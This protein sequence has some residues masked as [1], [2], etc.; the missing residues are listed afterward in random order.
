M[1]DTFGATSAIAQLIQASC[2][3]AEK[4]S[5]QRRK[6]EGQTPYINHPLQVAQIL[7]ENGVDD[8]DVLRAALLHD[9]LEDTETL[10]DELES[11]FGCRVRALVEEVSD[12]KSLPKS[13]RK[14]RQIEKAPTTSHAASLIKLADKFCNL[15]DIL[16]SPPRGWSDQRCQE[17]FQWSAQV[18]AGLRGTHDGLELLCDQ[19]LQDFHK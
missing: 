19:V 2:F 6:D 3:A 9:V 7:S 1:K 5:D 12:D 16:K 8:I 18:I 15:S 13:E 11:L 14:R 17:Y 10:A 4:H